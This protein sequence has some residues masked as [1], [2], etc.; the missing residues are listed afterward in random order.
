MGINKIIEFI[1]TEK[2]NIVIEIDSIFN[3]QFTITS[4]NF[5]FKDSSGNILI[6]DVEAEI[7]SQEIYYLLDS[8]SYDAGRYIAEFQYV[9]NSE[10]LITRLKIAIKE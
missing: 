2:K 6:D 8:T 7:D 4:A 10:R 3:E 5:T 9:I 1:K